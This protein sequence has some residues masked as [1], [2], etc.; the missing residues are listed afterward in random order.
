MILDRPFAIAGAREAA[1]AGPLF[2]HICLL[3]F[4]IFMLKRFVVSKGLVALEMAM[5]MGTL[6]LDMWGWNFE[7]DA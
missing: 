7:R 2:G 4:K 6:E 3:F 1:G 5:A